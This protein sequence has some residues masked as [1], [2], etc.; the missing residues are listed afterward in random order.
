M[1][2]GA[3]MFQHQQQHNQ[4]IQT[5]QAMSPN[6]SG[7]HTPL[8]TSHQQGNILP[9]T[10]VG[11]GPVHSGST[12]GSSMGG[13]SMSVNAAQMIL[14]QMGVG[15]TGTMTGPQTQ[16]ILHNLTPQQITM[17][18]QVLIYMCLWHTRTFCIRKLIDLFLKNFI[19]ANG[20]SFAIFSSTTTAAGQQIVNLSIHDII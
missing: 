6:Q 12:G 17:F 18:Q 15:V 7:S 4:I 1:C 14:H 13:S 3:A 10:N 8:L 20:A 16:T 19:S 2:T 11:S 9:L 5:A